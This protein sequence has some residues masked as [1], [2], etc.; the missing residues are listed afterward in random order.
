MTNLFFLFLL[1]AA[2][3]R[4]LGFDVT[5]CNFHSFFS[6]NSNFKLFGNFI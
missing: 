4:G 1:V 3:L 6:S 5:V 2:Q